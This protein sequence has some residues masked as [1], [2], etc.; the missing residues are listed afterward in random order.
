MIKRTF[1]A[2]ITLLLLT[3]SVSIGQNLDS[4]KPIEEFSYKEPQTYEIGGVRVLGAQ[5]TDEQGIIA[6]AG[7][8]EGEIIRIPSDQIS[9]AIRKLWKQGLFVDVAINIEKKI[10]DIVFLQI[11]VKEYPR[12]SR[13]AYKGIP[14]GQHDDA[15]A[16]VRRYLHKGRAATPAM[17]KQAVEALRALYIDKGFFDV[18]VQVEE[19]EDPVLKNSVHWVFNIKKGKR[20]RIG[21]INFHGIEKVKKGKLYRIMKETKRNNIWALFKPSKFVRKAYEEDKRNLVNYYNTIGNRDAII[22]KDSV[23]LV[24]KKKRKIM[25]IDLHIDEGNTYRFGEINFKGNTTYSSRVL[26]NIIGIKKG[27][28]YNSDLIESRLKFDKNG[29]DITTLYMDNGHLFFSV[30]AVEKGVEGDSIDLE[31]RIVEGPVAVIGKVTIRGNTRTSEHV[32]RRELRTLPG[33]KF[34]RTDL[35]RS[36][37]ELMALDYFNP[38]TMDIKTPVNVERGTVDIEYVLEEKI[39]D[40]IELSAGWGGTT[41]FGTAGIKLT[42]FSLRKLFQPNEWNGLPAGDGQTLSLRIQTNGPRYQSY[43]FSFTE[44][45][46]GGKSPNSLTLAAYYSNFTN[47]YTLESS[48]LQRFEVTGVTLGWGTRLKFPDNYFVYQASLNYKKMDLLKWG[49]FPSGT[50]HNLNIQQTISRNS[51]NSTIFPTKG[52]NI[53]LTLELTIPYSLFSNQNEADYASMGTADKFRMVEYHKWD[54]IAEWYGQLAKNFV[55]KLG[56]KMGFLGYYNP[57]LGL[58]PFDRYELGGNG[59]S[60]QM[61]QG[62]DVVSLRG[63]NTSDLS[64]NG[65]G[66]A[67]YN[68][69]SVEFRY[70]ISPNPNATIWVLAFAE[71]GNAWSDV[72]NY[73][74]FQLRRSAGLGVR[75][76][77]PMFGTLGFDYGIGFDKPNLDGVKDFTKYGT[78]NIVLGVEPK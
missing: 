28:V 10:G 70:L 24:Q 74:P 2:L 59:V 72:K 56:M 1:Y 20:I 41:V 23:Y 64:A 44:P 78:F 76:F 7:L 25:H 36:Q 40:Q 51:L 43:N 58:T 54:F 12:F 73:N 33:N 50:Y 77:L 62:R 68:K 21:T 45:W 57:N 39:S 75:I 65:E 31:V 53:A 32:I 4:L 69:F 37:R 49:T 67:A 22:L 52:A 6:I 13:H 48:A 46:L 27:D 18:A 8:T 35:I 47:G 71:A 63:Y 17:K 3:T 38:A 11:V 55:V 9:K 30:K 34:S 29:R 16:A 66:A 61:V 15:N 26:N 5:Y 60:N 14:K 19:A 42:N